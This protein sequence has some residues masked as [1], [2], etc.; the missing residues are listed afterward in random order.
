MPTTDDLKS[1][2][3]ARA[4]RKANREGN[5]ERAQTEAVVQATQSETQ[6]TAKPVVN[7]T[8][9]NPTRTAPPVAKKATRAQVAAVGKRK[10]EV[11]AQADSEL[12]PEPVDIEEATQRWSGVGNPPLHLLNAVAEKID[13]EVRDEGKSVAAAAAKGAYDSYIGKVVGKR[14]RHQHM[15]AQIA[16]GEASIAAR[17]EAEGE[18]K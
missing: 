6:E 4:L 1:R 18:T 10:A 16:A 3:N 14:N 2:A 17:R 13:A 11:Q 5:V 15:R 7:P 8:N 12:S 9:V